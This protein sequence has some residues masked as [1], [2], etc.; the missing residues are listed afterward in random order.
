[1]ADNIFKKLREIGIS[2][3]PVNSEKKPKLNSWKDYQKRL[4]TVQECENWDTIKGD[5]IAVVCG[6]ISGNLEVIDIDNKFEMAEQIYEDIT[7]KITAQRIDLLD[8]LVFEKSKNNGYHIIYRCNKIE[9][10][11]K[12][13]IYLNSGEKA[14]V[15]ETRGE[16]GYC[17]IY[18]SPGYQQLQ[19]NILKV[20]EITEEERDYLFELCKLYNNVQDNNKKIEISEQKN[21]TENNKNTDEV[22]IFEWYNNRDD[23]ID[24][25][26]N[27][28]WRIE[29]DVNDDIYFTRPGKN[30]GTS[31]T[32][33]KKI[34]SFFVFSS[35]AY[36]LED[37]KSYTPFDIFMMLE[38]NGDLKEA[39][40]LL[41]EKYPELDKNNR[42]NNK[43][44]Q[45]KDKNDTNNEQNEKK[46][47]Q[48]YDIFEFWQFKSK[49]NHDELVI[50]LKKLAQFL[51]RNDF[52]Y[53]YK[54]KDSNVLVRE[55]A[56][57]IIEQVTENYI[58][59]FLQDYIKS[60]PND[61]YYDNNEQ[62]DK[63]YLI[64]LLSVLNKRNL[65]NVLHNLE[66]REL[67]FNKDT[68]DTC[69][70]Y[71]KN[72]IVKITATNVE[73]LQYSDLKKY[74]WKEN[75]IDREYHT[76]DQDIGKVSEVFEFH[77]LVTSSRNVFGEVV[78]NPQRH[79]AL[80]SALG[81]LMHNYKGYLDTKAIVFCEEQVSDSGGRTG[82]TLTCQMLE[83]MGEVFAKINGRNVDFRNR[84]LFQNVEYNTN[85]I[86]ID[87]TSKRFNFG[88][89]YSIITNGLIVEKK[90][91]TSIQLSHQDTPKF[92]ITTNQ[93]LTDDSNSGRSR[94]FEIEFS[95]YFSDDHTPADEFGHLFFKDWDDEQWNLFFGYMI[96]SIQ[97]YL[98]GGLM[99]YESK[100]LKNRKLDA[101][102][103][104]ENLLNFCDSICYNI[105]LNKNRM[106]NKE[107]FELWQK[108]HDKNE[109]KQADITRAMNK[110]LEISHLK[111][112]KQ[113]S[114]KEKGKTQRG[115]CYIQMYEN[116]K[117]TLDF[118]K[119][120]ET[121]KDNVNTPF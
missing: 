107:I 33:S 24:I 31:A 100:S 15:I 105:I 68:E 17:I 117:D 50:D 32:F 47:E 73:Y 109:Y 19:K 16:G 104:D 82:K 116:S 80:R 74:I 48:K 51:Y 90:N 39:V 60:L 120:H 61:Y 46:N 6:R 11:Q 9:G 52:F 12:L 42:K 41:L 72:C 62:F 56:K 5:G 78:P 86:S 89:L 67:E 92:V 79:N 87:D 118:I 13:A 38:A 20:E 35:N 43:K 113:M 115:F 57:N 40:K 97:L 7:R 119:M 84:F 106:P 71:F 49:T 110:F 96:G 64:E 76:Q 55:V 27:H 83:Q 26:K 63:N 23:F 99:K 85:I 18:P 108:D 94:K 103:E 77:K 4:P 25:L 112:I 75:I 37:W 30:K 102:F 54:D 95:D 69:Y 111:V 1:M 3:I 14:T 93:V 45:K 98:Y 29:K 53:Y 10:N 21:K 2:S 36:P 28:G 58:I 114:Y 22:N 65:D 101:Y 66:R 59:K 70:K 44:V 88:G 121:K 8:K 34:R 91:K 81:Y